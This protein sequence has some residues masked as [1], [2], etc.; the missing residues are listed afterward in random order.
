MDQ[1]HGWPSPR[2]DHTF[3]DASWERPPI[4]SLLALNDPPPFYP[5]SDLTPL[6]KRDQ[7]TSLKDLSSSVLR[8]SK[9]ISPLP[10]SQSKRLDFSPAGT[11]LAPPPPKLQDSYFTTLFQ[12]SNSKPKPPFPFPH[13]AHPSF[14][15]S[16]M[17]PRGPPMAHPA[18][19]NTPRVGVEGPGC[20]CRSS[21]CL[22][23][24][25]ECLRKNQTCVGCNCFGCENHSGSELRNFVVKKIEKKNLGLGLANKRGS[26]KGCN[27]RKS[28]CLKN[29]CECHQFGFGCSAQCKCVGCLNTDKEREKMRG[30]RSKM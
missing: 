30:R 13:S 28:G 27:C 14:P 1:D 15:L 9:N 20:N 21:R 7:P 23:L 10:H 25:C 12:T 17:P 4:G 19:A 6:K 5:F 18:L 26:G 2:P 22:K 11:A 3:L 8:E 16:A 24:Y 29:Y